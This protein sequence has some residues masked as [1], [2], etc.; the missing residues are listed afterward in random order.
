MTQNGRPGFIRSTRAAGL[1]F[2]MLAVCVLA[3]MIITLPAIAQ[4]ADIAP[5]V[6]NATFSGTM[7]NNGWYTGS[8]ALAA[9]DSSGGAGVDLICYRIDDGA[10]ETAAGDSA[11]VTAIS[12]NTTFSTEG[13]GQSV[14]GVAVDNAGNTVYS[15]VDG[16]NIDLTPPDVVYSLSGDKSSQGWF[17]SDVKVT[18]D[19]VDGLS[20]VDKTEYSLDRL[21]LE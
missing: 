2:I 7:G 20:G 5:P 12:G 9:A 19:A 3:F 1:P 17:I 21:E 8:L 18:L 4:M 6:T 14:T 15:T 10:V 11:S 13:Y 16:I